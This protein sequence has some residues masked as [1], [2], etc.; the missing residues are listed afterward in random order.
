MKIKF[1]SST[2]GVLLL[3]A[4]C[5]SNPVAT[6]DADTFYSFDNSDRNVASSPKAPPKLEKAMIQGAG[7][8]AGI[9]IPK[10]DSAFLGNMLKR[11]KKPLIY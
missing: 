4:A 8:R 9:E 11:Q 3:L 1:G 2:C 6:S 5:S 10:L 7:K